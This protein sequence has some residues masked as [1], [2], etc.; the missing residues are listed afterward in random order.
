MAKITKQDIDYI[1]ENIDIVSLV[2]EYVKLEKRGQNYLGLCPFHNEKTPSFTVS[3]E[4]KIAHCFGCGK[5]GN[6][7]QFVSLI[8]NITYNQAIVKLGTRLGLD[9]ESN[10]N[11]EERYDLNNEHDLMYYGHMLLADYYNYILMN[12]KEAEEALKYLL[13]RGLSVDVIKH[14]NIGYAPRENNIAL[15]FFNSNKI[16][17]NIMVEAGLLGKNETGDYYD[18]FK[19]RVMFPIKNNQNQVV[20][21]SGRTMSSDKG[22]PKYYNTHETKIFEKRTVLY[23]FSDARAF[24]AKENEVIFCEGYMDVIKAHQNGIKNAVALMGTNIDNN[25]LNEILSLVSKVTLSL[26]NDEAGSKA[27]IEIGN[28]II[29]KTDNVYKLRFSGAKDL[30]EFLTEKN[31]KNPD[32]DAENYLKN[33]KDHYINYK[34][35]YCKNDSKS[36]IEQ[37]IKYKNEILGNIAYIEDESLK[38]I[39]LTNLAENFG[40]ERQ[41]LL[42]ELGQ[43]NVKRKKTVEQWVAPTKPELLFRATNYDKKLCKLFKYFF[44]DRALFV[45]KYNELEQCYF[46]QE[47][48]LNLMDYLVIYY[49]NNIEFHIHKFIHSLEDEEVIRLTTYIDENDFLIED[50]PSSEVVT[51]YIKYFSR[52]EITLK[53]IKDRLR[54]AIQEMDIETQKELLLKLKQLKK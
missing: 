38:Y 18:V 11:K 17:L 29:Q 14:F 2:S 32:F 5:G 43:V 34:I 3:P 19:D 46:P 22:V 23:N 25:K 16:D 13:D 42:K 21:F 31:S 20:A 26:D 30:D 51:D 53:E 7:F 8:E 15:N 35:E 52:K 6:I 12:T 47:A 9:I 24:I 49:N 4:K 45:E 39:L 28:R 27:Q 44:V 33:N 37:R 40:I 36:N 41:V 54:V 10:S 48:F 50:N 1:F